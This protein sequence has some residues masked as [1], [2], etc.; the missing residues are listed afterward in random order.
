MSDDYTLL[1]PEN[2]DL[3]FDVAGLGSRVA[4]AL[5]DYT[6]LGLGYLILTL[7]VSFLVGFV[8]AIF[9]DS[10][11]PEVDFLAYLAI[12]LT[13]ILAF[14]GWWGYFI[15]TEMLWNGQSIG[16]RR[17]GLRVVR[18]GGQPISL[19]ASL[20]RNLLR[21]VDL[22]AFIGVIVMVV[23][24]RSRRLGDLAAGTLVIR[25]PRFASPKDFTKAF[26]PIDIP[27]VSVAT[28]DAFPNPERLGAAHYSLLRDFFA[29]RASLPAAGADRLAADLAARLADSLGADRSE[30]GEPVHFLATAARA[31]E[32]RQHHPD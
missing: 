13:V 6:I 12:A 8:P 32:A 17:L 9:R 31:F 30:I 27:T 26:R 21:V 24:G 15:L 1:T 2:V 3:R 20:V 28:I 18:A 19:A 11:D 29:R 4:A 5:I 23:D 22:I 10:L 14:F 25:E 16:K 7:G